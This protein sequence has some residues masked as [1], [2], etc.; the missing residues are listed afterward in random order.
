MKK[1]S[2]SITAIALITLS[3]CTSWHGISKAD[4]K[5]SYYIVTNTNMF[6]IH[7]GV[8]LCNSKKSG[9][10]SCKAVTVE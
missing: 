4:K 7:P 1:I 6:G 10:L 9:N 8:Q 3:G 5:D 2:L